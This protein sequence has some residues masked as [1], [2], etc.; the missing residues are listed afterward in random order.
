MPT[1]MHVFADIASRFGVDSQNAESVDA[2]YERVVPAMSAPE[3]E[4]ILTEL[5][6]RESEPARIAPGESK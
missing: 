3:R 5:L 2:F 4:A 1:P 6:A